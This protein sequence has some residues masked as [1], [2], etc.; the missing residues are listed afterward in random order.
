MAR[1]S[2]P[3]SAIHLPL[4]AHDRRT[5]ATDTVFERLRKAILSSELPAGTPLIEA[6]LAQQ[7]GVSKTPVREALQRLSQSGLVDY[8][9]ARGATVHTL[10][11]GEIRDSFELRL[12]LEPEA[13]RQSIPHF[14]LDDCHRLDGVLQQA[15]A[16]LVR[17]DSAELS[18][19]NTTFH[20][21][22]YRHAENR[23]MAG[24][25][26]NLGDLRQ[27]MTIQGW[28][29]QN[30]SAREW[31]EHQGIFEAA[32]DGDGALASERLIAHIHGFQNLVLAQAATQN[33]PAQPA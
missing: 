24:W 6:Q 18:R 8:E 26:D 5:S 23:L 27:L 13:L 2:A 17:E 10:T 14:S 32:C 12:L 15:Q 19:L 16:A 1:R 9:L 3:A 11:L 21:A 7:L 22:L 33:S 25:L 29:R 30:R 4:G 28:A 20:R 31:Q